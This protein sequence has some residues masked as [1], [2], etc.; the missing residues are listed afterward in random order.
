[1][2]LPRQAE[3]LAG[4]AA[5]GRVQSRARLVTLRDTA[6]Q[7]QFAAR[8]WYAVAGAPAVN[9][10]AAKATDTMRAIGRSAEEVELMPGRMVD[11]RIL[12]SAQPLGWYGPMRPATTVQEEED[13][14][15]SQQTGR[16][17]S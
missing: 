12:L 1:V 4:A 7:L 11:V 8:G 9:G 3:R 13:E 5:S 6:A 17:A 14:D 15:E 10:I 16:L 2:L